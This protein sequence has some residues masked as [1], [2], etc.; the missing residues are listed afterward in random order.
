MAYRLI[1]DAPANVFASIERW[2]DALITTSQET[3]R[4]YHCLG[5]LGHDALVLLRRP[6]RGEI[7]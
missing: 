3:E 2:T 5:D 6:D 4:S 1:L 7:D